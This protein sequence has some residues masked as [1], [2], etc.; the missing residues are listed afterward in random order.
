MCLLTWQLL[1]LHACLFAHVV[2][3][4]H[5]LPFHPNL[6]LVT[7]VPADLAA[8]ADAACMPAHLVSSCFQSTCHQQRACVKTWQLPLLHAHL[9]LFAH[10][11]SSCRPGVLC[12][13]AKR[14][15]PSLSQ[16][17][18]KLTPPL[19]LQAQTCQGT[20]ASPVGHTLQ[21]R[22]CRLPNLTYSCYRI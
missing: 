8:A 16:S 15:T 3:S 10:L 17:S 1:M 9:R 14:Y 22:N 7:P 2:S 5:A 19:H 6:P 21:H 13:A 11:V 4:C 20:A 12:S 18:M